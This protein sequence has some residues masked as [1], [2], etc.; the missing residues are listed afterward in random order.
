MV[1]GK[2]EKKSTKTRRKGV[3]IMGLL[4]HQKR[5]ELK[6]SQSLIMDRI[7]FQTDS[8]MLTSRII[9]TCRNWIGDVGMMTELLGVRWFRRFWLLIK[10]LCCQ[11]S[12]EKKRELRIRKK[13][14]GL[15]MHKETIS[16]EKLFNMSRA[17][18]KEDL[19]A[20]L[21][22]LRSNWKSI[23]IVKEQQ[24]VRLFRRLW[25]LIKNL[26]CQLSPEK[27]REL[28]IRKKMI[29]LPM[30]KETM[31]RENVQ[32]RHFLKTSLALSKEDL[33]ALLSQLRRAR[34][35]N[36]DNDSKG[37]KP[38]ERDKE[39]K[40]KSKDKDKDKKKE[41]KEKVKEISKPSDE[42]PKLEG[43]GKESLDAFSN[44]ALNLLQ[45]NSKK[46]AAGGILGKR[47]ELEMN[48][49]L[50]ENG[51]LPHKLSRSVSSHPVVENGRKSEPSQTVLQF[52]SEG[53]GAAS[54]CKADI[55]EHRI[56]GLRGPE[57]LNA[58]S[59]KP[60][61]SRVKVNENGGASAKPPHPDSKYL[62]EILS[63]PKMAD[64]SNLDDQEW[65]LG[66]N[67]SGSK[68]PK[69][70]SPEIEMTPQVW[71]EAMQIESLLDVYALPYVIPY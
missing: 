4:G 13:L 53:Q 31:S 41:R 36:T 7:M 56:N 67:G 47:K 30:H 33:K 29:G 49:Y 2:T 57:Q 9:N 55:K 23:G 28:R 21:S 11:I 18:T 25:F 19:K 61:S 58:F 1:K 63:I 15:S 6:G 42:Q 65:L 17:L 10:D 3:G 66:G 20:L 68:K 5:R 16:R 39:K 27:K 46:S 62:S 34:K 43:N 24:E 8:I 26:C 44:K 54:D 38:K 64:E 59:T 50:H 40:V 12:P 52:L 32:R 51:F 60:S 69:V 71:A 22:Q 70:G 35:K 48:G 37:H 45:M 14:I